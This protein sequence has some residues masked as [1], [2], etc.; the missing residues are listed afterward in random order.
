M[1]SAPLPVASTCAGSTARAGVWR[2]PRSP[3]A[4]GRSDD[5]V[6]GALVRRGDAGRMFHSAAAGRA[7][8]RVHR[9]PRSCRRANTLIPP[10][11]APGKDLKWRGSV[12]RPRR[13]A[14]TLPPATRTLGLGRARSPARGCSPS[15]Y[16]GDGDT[17]V[18]SGERLARP[19][20]GQA[21]SEQGGEVFVCAGRTARG[22][23]GCQGANSLTK[24]AEPSP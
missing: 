19:I 24:L 2:C 14:S 1:S 5:P 4:F 21:V 11:L 18:R 8:R 7:R 13:E 20:G 16:S 10:G 9:R 6:P 23:T 17:R 3:M 12:D 15:H 22:F